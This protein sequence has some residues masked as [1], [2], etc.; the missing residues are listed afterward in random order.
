MARVLITRPLPGA[1]EEL[2]REAGHEVTVREAE[3]PP[4]PDELRE[5]AVE[6]EPD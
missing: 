6:V 4:R 1:P 3:L 2:L 5:L